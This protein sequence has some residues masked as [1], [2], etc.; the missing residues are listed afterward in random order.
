MAK[1]ETFF[2]DRKLLNVTASVGENGVNL[3]GDVMVVQAML[4]YALEEIPYFRKFKFP[5]PTGAIDDDTKLLIKGFQRF[6]RKQDDLRVAVDGV[7]DRAI[8]EKPFGK[9]LTW[10]ILS[11]NAQVLEMRLLRGGGG[12]SEIQDLCRRYPQLYSVLDDAPVGSLGLS[13][14]PSSRGVGSLNLGLE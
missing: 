5:E 12:G 8:G 3:K 10:T 6:L 13:L 11:L 2:G 14:E 7:I 9:R 4:K 1:I